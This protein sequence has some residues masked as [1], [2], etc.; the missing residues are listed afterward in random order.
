MAEKRKRSI[1]FTAEEVRV[2]VEETAAK[3]DIINGEF[4]ST[5][6][7]LTKDRAWQMIADAV[8][9]LSP[10]SRTI[11]SVSRINY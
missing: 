8:N 11:E 5:I 6:T 3:S 1:N 2:L 10:V 9:A 7:K 4:S